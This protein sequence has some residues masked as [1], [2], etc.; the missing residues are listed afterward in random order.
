MNIA[1]WVGVTLAVVV[2]IKIG[3]VYVIRR[4]LSESDES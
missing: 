3:I 4:A 2:L 1:L